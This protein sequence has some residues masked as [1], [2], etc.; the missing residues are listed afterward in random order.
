MSTRI[1][2]LPSDHEI[3]QI[4]AE[5]PPF[6]GTP[7]GNRLIKLSESVVVKFGVGVRKQEAE[8]QAYARRYVDSA[9]LYVPQVFRFFEVS[10]PNFTIGYLLMEF[11][12]GTCLQ[13]LNV[14]CRP[15]VIKKTI[16]ATRHLRSIP[17]PHAH[18]PGPAGGS[19]AQGYLWSD[20]GAGS[21]FEV[22]V[23]R[24]LR[25]DDEL[26]FDQLL[27]HLPRPSEA[28]EQ[29]LNQLGIPAFVETKYAMN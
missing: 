10:Y 25:A 21:I 28:D 22:H 27:I 8:N 20:N 1:Q 26:W 6:A 23:F 16:E 24:E 11:I 3:V 9:I 14:L 4:C 13:D 29:V 2:P 17:V 5:I 18:G 7:H 15:D 19:P 12:D